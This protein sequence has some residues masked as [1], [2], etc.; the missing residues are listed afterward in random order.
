MTTTTDELMGRK[1]ASEADHP[2]VDPALE[3]TPGTILLEEFLEPL[4]ISQRKLAQAMGV[5][6]RRVN[7]IILGKRSITADTA[8]RL[9]RALGTSARFWV[10]LQTDYDL[11]KAEPAVGEISRVA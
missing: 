6:P 9:G 5:P 8:V 10:N 4:G 1:V 2:A 11:S 3:V 7:E